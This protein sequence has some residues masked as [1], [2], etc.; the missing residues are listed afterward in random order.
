MS[1][2]QYVCA[3]CESSLVQPGLCCED[4]HYAEYFD[5]LFSELDQA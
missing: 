2:W 5:L 4:C 3:I 1:F